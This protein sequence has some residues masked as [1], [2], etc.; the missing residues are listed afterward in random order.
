LEEKVNTFFH[1]L[2]KV[3]KGENYYNGLYDKIEEIIKA[4]N[5]WMISRNEEKKAL[6]DAIQ[7]GQIKSGKSHTSSMF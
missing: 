5:K 3:Q 7:K 6:I 2:E 4:S 1:I